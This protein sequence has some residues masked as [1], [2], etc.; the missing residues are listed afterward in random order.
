MLIQGSFQ[1]VIP[2]VLPMFHIYG[3]VVNMASKL[4]LGCKLVTL[5][6]FSP[7]TFLQAQAEHKGTLLHLVPPIGEIFVSSYNI[8]LNRKQVLPILKR[9]FIAVLFLSAH[10]SVEQRHL[11][12]VSVVMSGAAPLAASDVERFKERAPNV[13]FT[14]VVNFEYL[15]KNSVDTKI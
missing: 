5:P 4:Q 9:C 11:E 10:P 3:L 13:V 7:D 1:D 12:S 14:Q 2:C 8:T 15:L 6:K